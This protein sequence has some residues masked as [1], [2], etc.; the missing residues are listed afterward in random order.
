LNFCPSGLPSPAPA[1]LSHLLIDPSTHLLIYSLTCCLPPSTARYKIRDARPILP[2]LRSFSEGGSAA[3][4]EQPVVS[5]AEPSRS[6]EGYARPARISKTY[7]PPARITAQKVL[8]T[9]QFLST[10]VKKCSELFKTALLLPIF[11]NFHPHFARFF[12]LHLTQTPQ[13][14]PPLSLSCPKTSTATAKTVFFPPKPKNSISPTYNPALLLPPYSSAY[15]TSQPPSL[16]SQ[17]T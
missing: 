9:V 16:Y 12:L 14:N 13:I 1:S 11:V 6:V 17:G 7:N 15:S 4:T 10:S 5:K 3:C 2:A 8:K